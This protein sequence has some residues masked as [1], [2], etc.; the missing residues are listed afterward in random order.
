L[1]G[2]ERNHSSGQSTIRWLRDHD[3]P[4]LYRKRALQAVGDKKPSVQYGFLTDQG[5]RR[6]ILDGLAEA[7]RLGTSGV[8]ASE[9]V[10]E[11]RTFVL[12]DL[13]KPE[14]QEG[15]HD[16]RVIAAAIALEMERFHTHPG[17]SIRVQPTAKKTPTGV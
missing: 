13:G 6:M 4:K 9:T 17:P 15:C 3:Y 16:D 12:N 2:V 1:V 10:R 14:A 5:S 11:M 8:M 7:V